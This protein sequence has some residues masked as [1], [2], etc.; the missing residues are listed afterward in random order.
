MDTLFEEHTPP[1]SE[2]KHGGLRAAPDHEMNAGVYP[3]LHS[4]GSLACYEK[5]GNTSALPTRCSERETDPN[6]EG[7]PMPIVIGLLALFMPRLVV[8]LLFFFTEWLAGI[9][10]SLLWL[11]LGFLFLP[12]TLLWYSAV[13]HWFG[14]EWTV[15]PIVGIMIAILIDVSPAGSRRSN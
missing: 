6:R 12:T 5:G 1:L 14:G 7:K 3:R 10:D 11:I 2:E 15:L 4:K 9:F 8:V 13:H